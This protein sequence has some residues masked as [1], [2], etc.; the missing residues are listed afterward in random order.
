MNIGKYIYTLLSTTSAIT[1]LVGTNI[2]PILLPQGAAYP[3]IVYMVN[4]APNDISK[5]PDPTHDKATVSFHIWVDHAFG[6]DGYDTLEAIETALRTALNG[7]EGTQMGIK[8]V[9]CRYDG[10]QDGRDDV[11]TMFIKDVT[12]TLIVKN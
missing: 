12:F 4:N 10:S 1:D 7:V 2:Y 6:L 5:C 11:M 8:V 9:S 3:A